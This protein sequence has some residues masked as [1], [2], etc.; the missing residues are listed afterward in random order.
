MNA[1]RLALTWLTIAPVS[2]PASVD[3][4]LAR[5]AIALVPF[6]GIA[7]GGLAAGIS[8]VGGLLGG[9]LAVAFLALATRGMHLD[10][11]ADTVDA[12]GS[13]RDP[14]GAREVMKSGPVGPFGAIA[15]A[16][17]I[18]I[19]AAAIAQLPWAAVILAVASGRIAVLIACSFDPAPAEADGFSPLVTGTQRWWYTAVWI[20][21]LAAAATYLSYSSA[22][23]VVIALAWLPIFVHHCTKRLG[24][25][26]GDVLGA[27]SELTVTITLIAL[28]FR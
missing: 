25:I 28:I 26:N 9:F 3:R 22:L 7:L 23:L 19:Q 11:L 1:I 24:W 15:I 5:R 17:V 27:A 21:A 14:A 20:V 16:L 13:Y 18:G 6:I 10:G 12:L 8:T 2:G 4:A